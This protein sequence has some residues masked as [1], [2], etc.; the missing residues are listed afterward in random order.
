MALSGTN[1][2]NEVD[3]S[4][5]T[6]CD[7]PGVINIPAGEEEDIQAV[8]DMVHAMQRVQFKKHQH[9]YSGKSTF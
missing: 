8:A 3:T 7:A 1:G 9:M 6:C 4:K 5:Y 2:T